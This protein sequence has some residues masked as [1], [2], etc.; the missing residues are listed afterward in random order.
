MKELTAAEIMQTKVFTI[1]QDA[2]IGELSALLSKN[3]ISG[4][5]VVDDDNR[6]VG[7]VSEGDLVSLDADIHFPHYIELLGNIIYLESVK[8][9]EERLAQAA[10]ARVR[11]IMTK[12]VRTVQKDTTLSEIATLMTEK[13]VNRLPVLD[14]DVLVGIV[15]R[16]D[17]VRASA[18]K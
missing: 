17:V 4:V 6:V 13:Q 9:Y 10:A 16:A 2:T 11:D 15:A 14:G 12:N 18:R 7:I 8:K 1:H 3:H 5:P